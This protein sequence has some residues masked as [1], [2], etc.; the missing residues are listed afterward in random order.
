MNERQS[1][2]VGQSRSDP[3]IKEEAPPLKSRAGADR[4]PM[5]LGVT[6][7]VK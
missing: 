1:T 7:T 6:T 3:L 2:T 5:K 4:Y